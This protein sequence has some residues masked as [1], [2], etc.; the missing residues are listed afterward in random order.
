MALSE[1]STGSWIDDDPFEAVCTCGEP[2]F[3]PGGDAWMHDKGWID[4]DHRPDPR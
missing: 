3:R 4:D 2:I 1:I